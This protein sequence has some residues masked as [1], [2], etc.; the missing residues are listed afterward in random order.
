MT[1]LNRASDHPIDGRLSRLPSLQQC[2]ELAE[3]LGGAL[4]GRTAW[5]ASA[6]LATRLASVLPAAKADDMDKALAITE[7]AKAFAVYP[8]TVA[9]WASDHLMATRR[10][11][12]AADI[13]EACKARKTEIAIAEGMAR[14]VIAAREEAEAA[15]RAADDEARGRQER[16]PKGGRR[17]RIAGNG[18]RPKR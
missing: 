3:M 16:E 6:A 17:R 1:A 7:M 4:A 5:E 8:A 11:R 13:H 9:H 2:R 10:F 12:P 18:W 15:K 14:K